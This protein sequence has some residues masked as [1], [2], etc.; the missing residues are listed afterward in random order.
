MIVV[1]R[2][3]AI[4]LLCVATPLTVSA[5]SSMQ[6]FLTNSNAYSQALSRGQAQDPSAPLQ[7]DL[8]YYWDDCWIFATATAVIN[9]VSEDGHADLS[10]LSSMIADGQAEIIP[11]LYVPQ[12]NA[13]SSVVGGGTS[14][15]DGFFFGY[16][17]S[18]STST[19]TVTVGPEGGYPCILMSVIDSTGGGKTVGTATITID[20]NVV[21]PGSGVST[22]DLLG[23]RAP[24][25]QITITV[26]TSLFVID[27]MTQSIGIG[28]NGGENDSVV[29]SIS[30]VAAMMGE[31][32]DPPAG[33]GG[34]GGGG[35]GGGGPGGPGGN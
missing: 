33:G 31:T 29:G 6:F 15:L 8:D 19:M 18:M 11:D 24:G 26:Q 23:Y 4:A 1:F 21:Q 28:A 2:F 16:G 30:A 20:G 13:V 10:S 3:L 7:T 35:P 34:P 22:Y 17:E 9:L 5:Q 32:G 27:P 12:A 25:S 14:S